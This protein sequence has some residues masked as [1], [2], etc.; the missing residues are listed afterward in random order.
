MFKALGQQLRKPSGFFGKLV[1]KMMEMRNK[2]FYEKTIKE[3]D[4][5]NGEKIFEIG[6]GPGLGI[7]FIANYSNNCQIDGID[8]SELMYKKAVKR[9]LKFIDRGI[10]N[11][12]FGDLLTTEP[13][14]QKYDKIFCINV[15]YFWNNLNQAFKKIHFLLNTGGTY[16]IY[17]AHEKEF[18]KLKFTKD[19]CKYTVEQVEA[20]LK[21][22]GFTNVEYKL[23]KGYYIKAK[24]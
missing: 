15:I 4:I 21:T 24:K 23:D 8:F 22:A 11:L 7:N 14:T 13:D 5:K 12:R 19:F 20:E 16:C 2:E 10:V 17:M 3:L 1:S 9:N 18:E 6:Y